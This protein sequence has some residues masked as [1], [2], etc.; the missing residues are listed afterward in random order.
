MALKAYMA[1]SQLLYFSRIIL[2]QITENIK[3]VDIDIYTEIAWI[4]SLTIAQNEYAERTG[5]V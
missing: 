4:F 2:T 5:E 1:T 3:N